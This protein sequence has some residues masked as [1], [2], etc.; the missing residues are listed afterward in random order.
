MQVNTNYPQQRKQL[1][2]MQLPFRRLNGIKLFEEIH[3]QSPAKL[4][5]H[6][7][8]RDYFVRIEDNYTPDEFYIKIDDINFTPI[9]ESKLSFKNN[10]TLY[11]DNIDIIDSNLK[12]CGAG[13]IMRLGEIITMLE[14]DIDKIELHSLGQAVYFHSKFKFEPVINDINQLTNYIRTDILSRENDKRFEQIAKCAKEWEKNSIVPDTE[15]LKHGNKILY[16]YLQCVNKFKLNHD[17][18]FQIYPGFDM[19][20]GK[21][22][23]ID[24]ME[25]FNKLFEKFGID[26]EI[27]ASAC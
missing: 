26:Y 19:M 13:T 7:N 27:K 8:R 18:E 11:N 25:Y 4:L 9:G 20:L 24:N 14:N 21:E 15:R 22:K 17:E 3:C 1:S 16:N 23:V 10:K 5:E 2:F 6:G 12:H